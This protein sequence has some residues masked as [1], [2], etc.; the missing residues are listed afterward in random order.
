MV[1]VINLLK[2]TKLDIKNSGH[3]SE[4]IAFIGLEY[5]GRSCNWE[6]FCLLADREYDDGFGSQEVAS[7]LI[8]VFSDGSFMRRTEYDGSEGWEFLSPFVKPENTLPMKS[9]FQD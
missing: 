2:E 1:E 3:S 6:E 5:S 8:I 7:D 4:D 9:L